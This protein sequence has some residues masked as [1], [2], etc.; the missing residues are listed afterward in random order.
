M[1]RS[2]IL[3]TTTAIA[4]LGL[5]TGLAAPAVAQDPGVPEPPEPAEA[6][7]QFEVGPTASISMWQAKVG[8][9]AIDDATA[10]GLSVESVVTDYFG[11]RLDLATGSHRFTP[12]AD[13]A[14]DAQS[15]VEARQ[16]T[17]D[18]V[19]VGRLGLPSLRA[20][21]VVPFATVGL[22]SVVHDPKPDSLG[23]RS[24]G[25]WEYGAGVDLPVME[26]F[27]ARI[28]WRRA[29]VSLENLFD[30]GTDRT[31]VTVMNDRLAVGAYVRF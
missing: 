8:R 12:P 11:I 28:E 13:S 7:L 16:Y 14:V 29:N 21:G 18:L 9:P 22:G 1:R 31:G 24:Q 10:V 26:H 19:A 6:P 3:P 2:R 27:G 4:A 30:D 5:L 25:A 20:I 15:S 17:V 23:T